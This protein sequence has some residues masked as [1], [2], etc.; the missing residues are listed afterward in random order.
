VTR[1]AKLFGEY[2]RTDGY[3]PLNF[4]SGGGG[5]NVSAGDTHSDNDARSNVVVVG[6]NVAF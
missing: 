4:I 6:V 2:I 3:A 5:P 1:S